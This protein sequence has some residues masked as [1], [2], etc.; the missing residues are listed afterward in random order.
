[1][2]RRTKQLQIDQQEIA[3]S[4]RKRYHRIAAVVAALVIGACLT[5]GVFARW[6]SG[7]TF[8]PQL[9]SPP[10]PDP[11]SSPTQAP[12]RLAKELIYSAGKLVATDEPVAIV[13]NDLAVWRV[14]PE[15]GTVTWYVLNSDGSYA[16]QSW[17]L[18][19][20]KPAQG[21]F[22]GDGKTDFAVFRPSVGTWYI[23]GSSSNAI[24]S[25]QFGMSTDAPVPADYDGDGRDD[26][27]VFRSSSNFWYVLNSGSGSLV[28]QQFAADGDLLVP[29]DYDGDGRDD[30]AVWRPSLTTWYVQQSSNGALTAFVWGL[31][32]DRPVPGDYDGDGKSDFAVWRSD[33]NWHI[34]LSAGGT[35]SVS[36][37]VWA[38]DTSVQGDYDGDGKTDIAVWRPNGGY[39][40]IVQSHDNSVRSA[41]WGQQGDIPVPAPYHR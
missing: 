9:H 41:Q 8:A 19:Q 11:T 24:S 18:A 39:W 7:A 23:L 1:M 36:W 29:S 16:A 17:G 35:R 32:G 38:S 34:H 5:A 30:L 26:I 37:G 31:A 13:P 40:Y 28:A 33:Q 12:L 20:D 21:D 10:L 14:I 2:S 3:A 25:V 4:A 6:K 27:A 15:S 22:D